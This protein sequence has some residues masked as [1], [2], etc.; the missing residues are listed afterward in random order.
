MSM[1]Q[2]GG[3]GIEVYNPMNTMQVP[4]EIAVKRILEPNINVF[5]PE[6]VNLKNPRV[7]RKLNE[8]IKRQVDT[9]MGKQLNSQQYTTEIS[10]GFE[11]KNNQRNIVSLTNSHYAYSGGAHGMTI[12]RSLTMNIDTGEVYSLK[13]LFKTNA[14]YMKR[15]DAIIREQIKARQLQLLVEY[16]GIH[17]NQF[18]YI[19]DKALVIYF[20]LYDLLP[21]AFGFPYFVISVYEIE[22]IVKDDGA[23]GRMSS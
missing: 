12:Q 19:A 18:F 14:D 20:Q 1:Y 3:G 5:Y 15:L 8:R 21:Y 11:I 6:L 22:D 13:D 16:P 17:R 9:M 4:A 23:L 7:Q 2:K 10:G